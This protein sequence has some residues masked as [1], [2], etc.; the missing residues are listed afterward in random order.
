MSTER[1]TWEAFTH[2][3]N[4]RF[5]R[6]PLTQGILNLAVELANRNPLRAYDAV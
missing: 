5:H 6:V 4:T 2:D 3:S 1:E